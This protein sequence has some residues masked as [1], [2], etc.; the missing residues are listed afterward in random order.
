MTGALSEARM[1][2][3]KKVLVSQKNNDGK[4]QDALDE[5]SELPVMSG[6]L[7]LA[8]AKVLN[9][10]P[11]LFFTSIASRSIMEYRYTFTLQHPRLYMSVSE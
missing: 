6:D 1:Q 11:R 9:S 8:V 2:E 4:V 7:K 10:L 3:V 5:V